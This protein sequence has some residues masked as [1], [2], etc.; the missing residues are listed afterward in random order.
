MYV[1]HVF[2]NNILVLVEKK[3]MLLPLQCIF[4][5]PYL[6]FDTECRTSVEIHIINY[7][8]PEYLSCVFIKMY[9]KC[10][11]HKRNNNIFII[12]L[13]VNFLQVEQEFQNS[14]LSQNPQFRSEE[15]N[16]KMP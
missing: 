16:S 3:P 9:E 8:L 6:N 10:Y 2:N 1:V 15:I 14:C 13:P 5:C 7:F 11:T 4:V 12:S